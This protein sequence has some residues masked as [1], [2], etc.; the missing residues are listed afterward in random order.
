MP[1]TFSL[2]RQLSLNQLGLSKKCCHFLLVP[3][4]S[5]LELLSD[6]SVLA[7]G[8]VPSGCPPVEPVYKHLEALSH[9]FFCILHS[10]TAFQSL[11]KI[12]VLEWITHSGALWGLAE[13]KWREAAHKRNCISVPCVCNRDLG[14]P[15]R[16]CSPLSS[17]GEYRAGIATS[18]HFKE[19]LEI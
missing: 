5:F 13:A 17:V 4:V 16:H 19:K 10:L 9:V 3:P 18:C 12:Q 2:L 8:W 15:K 6:G 14:A 1:H 7:P 11:S